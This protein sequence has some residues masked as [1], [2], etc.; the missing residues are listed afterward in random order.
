MA[1]IKHSAPGD[2]QRVT[3]A[4]RV[5]ATGILDLRDKHSCKQYGIDPEDAFGDWQAELA[6][7]RQPA[8]WDVRHRAEALGAQ[9]LID[10]SRKR[11]GL[12]HLTL[13]RWNEPAAPTVELL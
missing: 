12:W 2:P 11:P 3:V 10:P 5:T 1:L 8:S 7:D 6:A 9:G 4:A 13:F